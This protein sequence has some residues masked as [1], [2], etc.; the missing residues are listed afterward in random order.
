MAL[1]RAVTALGKADRHAYK[2]IVDRNSDGLKELSGGSAIRPYHRKALLRE[3]RQGN[4]SHSLCVVLRS[5][6]DKEDR[7]LIAGLFLK[8]SFG[9]L[10][11]PFLPIS[12]SRL[13]RELRLIRLEKR[14]SAIIQPVFFGFL[15]GKFSLFPRWPS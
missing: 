14:C 10:T 8:I 6:P 13:D 15:E 5:F 7:C 9:K 3:L 11:F 1:W 12:N 4:F 2:K